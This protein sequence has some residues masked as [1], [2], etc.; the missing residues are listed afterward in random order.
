[1]TRVAHN[2]ALLGALLI[3]ALLIVVVAIDSGLVS[4]KLSEGGRTINVEFADTG[5]LKKGNPVRV[6]GVDAGRVKDLHLAAGGRSAIVELTVFDSVG[7]IHDDA[8]ARIRWRTALGGTFAVDL[9]PGSATRPALGDRLIPRTRTE[10]QVEIEDAIAFDRGAA[11]DGLRTTFRE[12][13]AAL[14]PEPV[15]GAL[16][17]L[18]A[19]APALAT[20]LGAVRGTSEAGLR[21]VVRAAAR[22]VRAVDTPNDG[23][24]NLIAGGAATVG[25]TA[26]RQAD[27][28]RTFQLAAEIQPQVRT[29][30][31][32]LRSTL[33]NA[34][35]L[36]ARLTSAAP[37]VAPALARLRPTVRSADRLLATTRPVATG[38]QRTAHSLAAASTRGAALV[39]DLAPSVRRLA[40]VILPALAERDPI[41]ELRTYQII[42][43]TIASLNGAASTFDSEGHLFRF[44]ALGGERTLANLTPCNVL[45]TDPEASAILKCRQI[46]GSVKRALGVRAPAP[47]GRK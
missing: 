24:R 8:S 5:Q 14:Q 43:P 11:R 34:D 13:P 4:S 47:K 28:Q 21:R 32:R 1:M 41:T 20:T 46:L 35:P 17:Q 39:A 36:I 38:L 15:T 30:L 3:G 12:L 45:L 16:T 40:K 37:E 10:N 6:D 18:D 23:V 44:P 33:A 31:S 19:N 2:R 29:T 26:A 7:T 42:G 22:T 27:L 25:V 9:N